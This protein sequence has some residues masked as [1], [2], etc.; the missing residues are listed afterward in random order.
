M[1]CNAARFG[2]GK[3]A[4]LY[5]GLWVSMAGFAPQ[6]GEASVVEEGGV[7]CQATASTEL[8]K[9][10]LIGLKMRPADVTP[11]TELDAFSVGYVGCGRC[12]HDGMGSVR[13]AGVSTKLIMLITESQR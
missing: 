10:S 7:Q 4:T 9:L 8:P 11:D 1:A 12:R 13:S 5:S 3:K 2:Q 6:V